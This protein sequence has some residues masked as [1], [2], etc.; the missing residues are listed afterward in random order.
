L[1]LPPRSLLDQGY[2]VIPASAGHTDAE[3][4]ILD[5]FATT[6]PP[7]RW[8]ASRGAVHHFPDVDVSVGWSPED[9]AW[10]I[11]RPLRTELTRLQRAARRRRV[12]NFTVVP[13]K[14][15]KFVVAGDIDAEDDVEK[16]IATML[17]DFVKQWQ[18]K[19]DQLSGILKTISLARLAAQ[20]TV[21]SIPAD[22]E[23]IGPDFLVS[24]ATLTTLNFLAERCGLADL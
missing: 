1:F 13:P 22:I 19:L 20:K 15:P 9:A 5:A 8:R 3:S 23:R 17:T 4:K 18:P 21:Q 24:V 14:G 10:M 11:V 16:V 12:L 2:A 6:Q 7:T